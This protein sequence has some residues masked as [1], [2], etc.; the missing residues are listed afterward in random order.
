MYQCDWNMNTVEIACVLVGNL[1]ENIVSY[2]AIFST[3]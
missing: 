1:R 3:A 2:S